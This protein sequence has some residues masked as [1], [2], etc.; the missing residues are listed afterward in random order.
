M[1]W[2]ESG[3]D[4]PD[5]DSHCSRTAQTGRCLAG[6]D[7]PTGVTDCQVLC[8]S[9]T[10][11]DA[12]WLGRDLAWQGSAKPYPDD[13]SHIKQQAAPSFTP[14]HVF[15]PHLCRLL[16]CQCRAVQQA[17]PAQGSAQQPQP[18]MLLQQLLQ[19]SGGR[20]PP[21]TPCL[22]PACPCPACASLGLPIPRLLVPQSI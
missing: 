7:Q 17:S 12:I 20:M 18:S 16:G 9:C 15:V 22:P 3:L 14:N 21:S 19:R 6:T 8:K 5:I 10:R 4:E 13:N 1:A 11:Y 2:S